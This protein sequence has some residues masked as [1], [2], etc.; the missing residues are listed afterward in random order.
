MAGTNGW[1]EWSRHVLKELE[2]LN[3]SYEKMYEEH[4]KLRD[5]LAQQ[6]SYLDQKITEIK[7]QH[8]NCKIADVINWKAEYD[9]L[10]V[11]AAVKDLKE[12]KRDVNE[13]VS[14]PQLEKLNEDVQH[15]KSFKLKATTIFIVVQA[16]I[17]IFISLFKFQIIS[18]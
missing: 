6:T 15:L 7:L 5:S 4:G 16:I 11:L 10:G 8:T 14:V 9:E 12:W 3:K 1:S 18:L 13:I 17:S 2:R